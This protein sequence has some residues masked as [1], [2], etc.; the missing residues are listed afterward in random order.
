[1]YSIYTLLNHLEYLI[2]SSKV[3]HMNKSKAKT[4]HQN[5]LLSEALLDYYDEFAD[6]NEN[7]AFLCDAFSSLVDNHELLDQ[8]S[9]HGF[10][11]NADW[12]KKRTGEL[13]EKLKQ[14]RAL[15]SVD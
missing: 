10:A 5:T 13:K 3:K 12:I 11:R 2:K 9:I 4:N 8:T 6:F 1:M 7:C 15:D 14:I